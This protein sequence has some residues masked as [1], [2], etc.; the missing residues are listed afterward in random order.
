MSGRPFGP[1]SVIGQ[2]DRLKADDHCEDLMDICPQCHNVLS[3]SADR[4]ALCGTP[5]AAAS[6]Q[7]V[8]IHPD[9]FLR[10]LTGTEEPT[11]ASAPPAHP[12]QT[13][14][15]AQR[16]AAPA[17]PP[18]HRSVPTTPA[19]GALAGYL[20]AAPD[21]QTDVSPPPAP[22]SAHSTP[23]THQ[24]SPR[25]ITPIDSES[26][27]LAALTPMSEPDAPLPLPATEASA[28]R[29]FGKHLS[30]AT[31]VASDGVA[32]RTTRLDG[33][34]QLGPTRTH[35]VLTLTTPLIAGALL[36]AS[37]MGSYELQTSEASEVEA[38]AAEPL[39][40]VDAAAETNSAVARLDL[41]G[42]GII[43]QT[44]GFVFADQTILVVRSQIATDNRP[45]VL[46]SDGTTRPSEII[47]W[48]LTRNL[49]IVKTGVSIT[50]GLRWGVSSRVS[51]G[52]TVTVLAIDGPGTASSIPATITAVSAVNGLNASFELDVGA[53]EGSVVLN[54]DGFV[55]GVIDAQGVAQASDDIAPAM[56][57]IVL[58][59]ERPQA[60]CPMPPTTLEAD[61]DGDS[62]DGD[63]LTE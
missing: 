2:V 59:N 50:G 20:G 48:S 21:Q 7:S 17:P 13:S 56:S 29:S 34:V 38:A 61:T 25:G 8:G 35:R 60:V 16:N 4:C 37:V 40:N 15:P 5:R 22:A 6:D 57:R 45:S 36:V 41:D 19:A 51:N 30:T 27:G 54:S 55:V 58:A 62:A 18:R 52:D 43:G 28:P 14:T 11:A 33:T 1:V 47:G 63:T 24:P 23:P 39:S 10:Q 46:L 26:V 44:T 9:E 32:A 42:C 53:A 3:S 12:Q 31:N 49:A